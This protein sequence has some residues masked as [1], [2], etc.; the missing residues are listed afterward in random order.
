MPVKRTPE[1]EVAFLA[2]LAATCSVSRACEAAGIGRATVY[3]WR[4]ED[5]T[6]AA[7]WEKAK[8]V[9]ADILEDEA[10]RRAVE[11]VETPIYHEGK[12]VDTVHK[13]SDTLM[14]FLLK[15]AKPEVYKDRVVSEVSGPNG[16]PIQIDDQTA[17]TKL[18]A[19]MGRLARRLD[20]G[21]DLA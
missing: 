21:E 13:Y 14:I 1:K 10:V 17:A 12:C 20:N 8:A 5:P 18:E 4:D 16:A 7:R 19:I 6:F 9:G 11:G 3:E 2:A 15:G